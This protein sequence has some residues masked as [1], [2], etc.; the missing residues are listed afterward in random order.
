MND[1]TKVV[2]SQTPASIFE[3]EARSGMYSPGGFHIWTTM[4]RDLPYAVGVSGADYDKAAKFA[5]IE[6][7]FTAFPRLR[8][9]C[10]EEAAIPTWMDHL[11]AAIVDAAKRHGCDITGLSFEGAS[12][13][14]TWGD[15]VGLVFWGASDD[16]NERAAAFAEQWFSKHGET[17]KLFGRYEAQRSIGRCGVR[18]YS[19]FDNGASGWHDKPTGER[20][21]DQRPALVETRVGHSVSFV[22]YPCAD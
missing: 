19:R 4:E 12:L 17:F 15:K 22:Y 16:V 10:E 21:G 8:G 2:S 14:S 11:R 18:Y 5:T 6:A 9:W 20:A 13:D 3:R 7:A 1:K